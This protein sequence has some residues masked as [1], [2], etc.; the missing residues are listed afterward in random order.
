M[1]EAVNGRWMKI[2]EVAR[3]LEISVESI[4]MYERV[5]LLVSERRGKS[6]RVYDE[7]DLHWLGCIRRLISEQGLNIEGIRRLMALAPCWE[8]KPCP[9]VDKTICP[10]YQGVSQ[11]CW[12]MK[13]QLPEECRLADCRTCKV[14]RTAT[15]C[16]SLKP[17]LQ[18]V[19]H[20]S[21]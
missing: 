6:H 16:D 19:K 14:Y 13:Q 11:P 10:A 3:R 7:N 12:S 15:S 2:G 17:L 20:R 1:T 21:G 18:I 4:R 9:L 8:L 5:G